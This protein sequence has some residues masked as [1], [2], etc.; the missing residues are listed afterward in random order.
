MSGAE[1]N[2][3]S[4]LFNRHDPELLGLMVAFLAVVETGSFASA[5]K[6]LRQTPSTI[7]RKIIRLEESLGVRLLTRTTRTVVITEM[8]AIYLRYCQ[9]ISELLSSAEAEVTSMSRSPQGLLKLS[10]PVAFG[11]RYITPLLSKFIERYPKIEIEASYNDRYVQMV[12]EN[13][14]LSVRIGDLPD[15]SLVARKLMSNR[16][17]LVASPKYVQQFGAPRSPSDLTQHDCIRYIRY[18]SAGNIWKFTRESDTR[19]EQSVAVGG[20]FRCDDSSAVLTYAL[21]GTGIGIVADYI[22]YDALVQ[23]RL[24]HIMADW[25]VTPASNVYLCWPTTRLLMPK[26]RYLI[27]FLVDHLQHLSF[28]PPA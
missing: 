18:R 19:E 21:T 26:V 17:L 25:Q 6:I 16:R 23:G 3:H 2:F 12:E 10:M 4:K 15:S 14:D 9:S 1:G 22:C 24:I 5:A 20:S 28:D 27:D 8:G 13:F 7:S 11:E